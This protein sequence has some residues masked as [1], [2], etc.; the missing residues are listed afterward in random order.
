MTFSLI[1][2]VYDSVDFTA[3]RSA[4][5]WRSDIERRADASREV[6]SILSRGDRH[7]SRN[8]L[9]AAL[10]SCHMHTSGRLVSMNPRESEEQARQTAETVARRSYGRLVAFLAA[11][12]RDVAAAEDALS[13]AFASALA[14]WPRSGCPSNPEAWLLTVARRRMIDVA[15]HRRV[16][17]AAEDDLRTLAE[18]LDAAADEGEIPDQRLALMFVCAH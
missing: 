8:G 10:A 12:T 4:H 1:G 3:S 11:R 9:L 14:E 16:G 13:E 6:Y 17:E 5:S 15:R 7:S 18:S 2:T